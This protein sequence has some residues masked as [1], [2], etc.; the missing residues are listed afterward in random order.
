[1]ESMRTWKDDRYTPI[2]ERQGKRLGRRKEIR[3]GKEK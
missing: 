3:K 2:A 1:M